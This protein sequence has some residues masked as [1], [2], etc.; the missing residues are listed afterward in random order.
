MTEN[1]QR[2]FSVM[3]LAGHASHRCQPRAFF[4]PAGHQLRLA[5]E[6]ALAAEAGFASSARLALCSAF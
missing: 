5:R 3:G 4:A 6:R 1:C 2:T